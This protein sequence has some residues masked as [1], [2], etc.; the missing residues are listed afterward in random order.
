MFGSNHPRSS[1]MGKAHDFVI[2][3]LSSCERR[4]LGS[5]CAKLCCVKWNTGDEAWS[6][7]QQPNGLARRRVELSFYRLRSR[8]MRPSGTIQRAIT[9]M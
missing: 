3:E 9:T 4:F 6:G 5:E 2:R 7:C 8:T 1:G